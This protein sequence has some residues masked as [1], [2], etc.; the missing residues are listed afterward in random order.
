MIWSA[1]LC[2][3]VPLLVE[4]S[5]QE[6]L[7]TLAALLEE[8]ALEHLLGSD[9][10]KIFAVAEPQPGVDG[11]SESHG[12]ARTTMALVQNITREVIALDIPVVKLLWDL[13]VGD[14]LGISIFILPSL[15][16]FQS[17]H[18]VLI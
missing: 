16:S 1:R 6:W 9:T 3:H 5:V 13:R 4:I 17:F 18:K 12:V 8:V 11:L 7:A 15:G 10:L 2:H 14:S